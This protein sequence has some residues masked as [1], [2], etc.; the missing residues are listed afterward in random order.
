MPNF[1]P[2]YLSVIQHDPMVH[3][4][5]KRL[6]QL[7]KKGD[8]K[9]FEFIF[10]FY[11]EPLL[12]YATGIVKAE[13]E[14]IIQ[15]I[16]LKLWQDRTKLTIRR[17]LSA[18]LYRSVYNRC[19]NKIKKEKISQ[20]YRRHIARQAPAEINADEL[21]K[22]KELNRK[23]FELMDALPERSQTIFKLSRFQGLKYHEIAVKLS[24]SVKTVEANIS[25]ALAFFRKNLHDVGDEY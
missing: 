2:N 10:R 18:Y 20:E 23:F 6:L 15:D 1:T 3:S 5:E 13:A 17:S 22:F 25:K 11:Y 8:K 12:G 9:S 7:L 19:M 4:E 24:I 14:E 16:F 21:L